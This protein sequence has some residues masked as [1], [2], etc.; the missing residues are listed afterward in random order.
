MSSIRARLTDL[1]AGAVHTDERV[2][3]TAMRSSLT[4]TPFGSHV[5]E[6]VR[7]RANRQMI[8]SNAW[9]GIAA[10]HDNHSGRDC[11]DKEFEGHAVRDFGGL[12]FLPNEAVAVPLARADPEPTTRTGRY[13]NQKLLSVHRSF[14][15]SKLIF[16]A[17]FHHLGKSHLLR[18]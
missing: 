9:R 6:V 8:G 3:T 12:T 11:A 1:P 5:S 10:V 16:T 4:A 2:T 18:R 7:L 13:L 14:L 17:A 15:V